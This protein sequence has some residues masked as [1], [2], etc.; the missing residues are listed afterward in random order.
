MLHALVTFLPGMT[1]TIG[2]RELSTD[3]LQSGVANTASALVQL[4]GLAF[5]VA[6]GSSIA[7]S[8]FGEATRAAPEASFSGVQLGAGA[9]DGQLE[10]EGP[11]H[12]VG[13]GGLSGPTHRHVRD[14]HQPAEEDDGEPQ[15]VLRVLLPAAVVE[16]REQEGEK[17][18][19]EDDSGEDEA[20]DQFD[21]ELE[22]ELH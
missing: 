21:A 16:R 19:G 8:W 1:L 20:E 4:L 11:A 13:E 2:M 7:T 12:G 14:D 10:A 5:G 6:V 15:H 3:H 22:G 18:Q 9:R 17:T